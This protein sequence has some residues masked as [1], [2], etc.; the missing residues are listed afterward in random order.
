[1]MYFTSKLEIL[2]DEVV[3]EEEKV[4]HLLFSLKI[5]HSLVLIW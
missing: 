2:V 1:M 4:I 5:P 3:N